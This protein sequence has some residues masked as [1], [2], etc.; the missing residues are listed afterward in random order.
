MEEKQKY[1]C[2][3]C[4]AEYDSAPVRAR[5][6]LECDEKQKQEEERQRKLRLDGE[7]DARRAEIEA[8]WNRYVVLMN[9]YRNDYGE[10]FPVQRANRVLADVVNTPIIN[11][12]FYW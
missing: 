2:S 4:G 3:Y 8:A 6:E 9:Q 11:K 7:R 5:C 1:V 10:D 12:L